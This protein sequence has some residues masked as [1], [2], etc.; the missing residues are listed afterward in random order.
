MRPPLHPVRFLS[1]SPSISST[2]STPRLLQFHQSPFESHLI[3]YNSISSW[4]SGSRVCVFRGVIGGEWRGRRDNN[5]HFV[6]RVFPSGGTGLGLSG[7]FLLRVGRNRKTYADGGCSSR[8]LLRRL[9]PVPGRPV[10]LPGMLTTL[11]RS[12]DGWLWNSA[13]M[14]SYDSEELNVSLTVGAEWRMDV[15]K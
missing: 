8:M 6:L 2:T 11:G 4:V 12:S 15:L 5:H 14:W 1:P 3:S 10:Q 7:V 9:L 13:N